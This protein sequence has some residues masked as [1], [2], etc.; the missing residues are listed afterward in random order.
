MIVKREFK[1]SRQE[2]EMQI[3]V[4]SE[5]IRE[6]RQYRKEALALVEEHKQMSTEIYEEKYLKG[7]V[8]LMKLSIKIEEELNRE[9]VKL[10][11]LEQQLR[12]LQ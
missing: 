11:A 8:E 3:R 1:M 10:D 2:L 5:R 6:G 4:L 7:D 9:Y 12:E